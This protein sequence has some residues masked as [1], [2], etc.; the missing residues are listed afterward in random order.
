MRASAPTIDRSRL[1]RAKRGFTTRRAES[2]DFR[3]LIS[4]EHV[5]RS[6]DLLL[7]RIDAIG[8]HSWLE[9][10]DGRRQSLFVG[11][12]VLIAYGNR[13]APDYFEAIVPD[14]PG[15][16]QLVAAGGVAGEVLCGRNGL[17]EP[18]AITPAGF[19]GDREGRVLNLARWM[20][21]FSQAPRRVE[22]IAVLGTS[23]NAGKTTTAA[24]LV[25]GLALAGRRVG[26]AKV[27][28]TGSGKDLWMMADAGAAPVLDFT[29]AGHPSTYLLA[30]HVVDRVTA[31]LTAA[32]VRADCD[33]I[34]LEIAD[35]FYEPETAA[36]L[37]SKVFRDLVDTV[38]FAA[39]DAAG[40]VAGVVAL[41]AAGVPVAAISGRLT[42]SPLAIRETRIATDLPVLDREA[43]GDPATLDLL[44]TAQLTAA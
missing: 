39:S 41:K 25:R 8:Q 40:A 21:P 33:V 16:C 36:L 7:A 20:L 9:S 26:A 10:P 6:G 23:M 37:A 22:T 28:G 15:P 2:A 27:T 43:L 5:P 24:W 18:T 4:D 38:I 35:G 42:A 32:L 1:A 29:D 14:H 11:D 13:Y 30:P 19:I 31:T 44:R 34:V 12:E 3:T 17:K